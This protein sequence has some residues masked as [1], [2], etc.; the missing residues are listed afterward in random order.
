MP[1]RKNVCGSIDVAVLYRDINADGP[2]PLLAGLM[3]NLPARPL[4][5]RI[6]LS[7]LK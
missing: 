4:G 1:G 5:G 7:L 6:L 2:T 3:A